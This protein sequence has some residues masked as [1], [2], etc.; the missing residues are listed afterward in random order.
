MTATREQI[1]S[2]LLQKFAASGAFKTV[3]RRNRD[4]NESVPLE[5]LPMVMLVKKSEKFERP[6]PN[7]PPKRT[8]NMVAFVYTGVAPEDENAIPEA[9]LND[10]MEAIDAALAPDDVMQ[11]R[12]TLGGLVFS[13]M[14][15]GESVVGQDANSGRSVQ[16][17]P[18]S[19]LIP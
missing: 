11:N 4:P 5:Q 2:A 13:A 15:D 17:V 8:L 12:C 1:I 16:V 9:P 19:I 7:L 14:I 3:G 18:I 6:S 10:S